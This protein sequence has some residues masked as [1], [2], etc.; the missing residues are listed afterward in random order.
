[1]AVQMLER[2][3]SMLKKHLAVCIFILFAVQPLMDV[4][5]FWLDKLGLSTA[6]SLF[7]RMLVLAGTALA[8]FLLSDQKKYYWWLAAVCIGFFALHMGACAIAGYVSPVADI[9]NY[10]RVIQ[11]PLFALCFISFLKT[12]SRAFHWLKLGFLISFGIITLVVILSVVTGTNPYTYADTQMGILGWFSTTN[13]QASIV[14][15]LTPVLMCMAYQSKKPWILLVVAALSCGQLYF[16]GTRLAYFAVFASIFGLIFITAVNGKA[17]KLR[18]GIL[19]ITAVV[20]MACVKMSPMYEHQMTYAQSMEEKQSDLNSMSAERGTQISE[21]EEDK[22][23]NLDLLRELNQIYVYYRSDL[24]QRFGVEKVMKKCDYS[25]DV[26]QM[27][28]AR[29]SKIIFCSLLMDEEP[30]PSRLF[31]LERDKMV[32]KGETY[33]VENDFHGIYFLYGMVGLLLFIAFLAYFVYLVVWAL[34]KNPKKYFTME[35][36]A[37]GISFLLALANAYNT[38]GILRR[39]NASFYLSVIL[40]AIYYLVRVKKYPE[41]Q[42]KKSTGFFLS[43]KKK[44]TA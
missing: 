4:L 20:C 25:T 10:I 9:T 44:K 38:A 37:F 23:T 29:Q 43:R 14:S 15:M 22:L 34:I 3:R 24:V 21:V 19:L 39:P 7:L 33:D 26:S 35:A 27:T 41:T 16:L 31:G 36:G 2:C 17:D 12:N 6:P 42:K 11:I 5:S 28:G 1:M 18:Y 32:Y 30:F 13:S 40:A 8:G